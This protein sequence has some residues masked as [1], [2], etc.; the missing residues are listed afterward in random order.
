M[1][2]TGNFG[3]VFLATFK[4]GTRLGPN[5]ENMFALK[6]LKKKQLA[7]ADDVHSALAEQHA[8][9]VCRDCSFVVMLHAS[10]QTPANIFF[11]LELVHG[12]D[13]MFHLQHSGPFTEV[14]PSIHCFPGCGF[15][16]CVGCEIHASGCGRAIA[17][18]RLRTCQQT[19]LATKEGMGGGLLVESSADDYL[20]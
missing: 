15:G 19:D 7:D 5:A 20:I 6:V 9:S 10:F 18:N 11:L 16:P 1:L 17:E 14:W 13:L 12:G 4:D 3:K 8:L 2:G